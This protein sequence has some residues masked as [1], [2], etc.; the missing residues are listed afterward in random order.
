MVRSSSS[1][2]VSSNSSRDDSSDIDELDQRSR[3]L[4]RLLRK[5]MN[6]TEKR[7]S[8]LDVVRGKAWLLQD[9]VK[10]LEKQAATV[11]D[12]LHRR[13]FRRK[14]VVFLSSVI[15]LILVVTGLSTLIQNLHD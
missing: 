6:Q 7:K 11:R 8:V 14:V 13:S 4:T 3:N 1:S 5:N 9:Q 2:D 10:L 15:L 12:S